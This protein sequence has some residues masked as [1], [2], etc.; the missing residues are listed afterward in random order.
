MNHP[1]TP[2]SSPC[3]SNRAGENSPKSI[4]ISLRRDIEWLQGEKSIKWQIPVHCGFPQ[5]PCLAREY[6]HH[7]PVVD[8]F[9]VQRHCGFVKPVFEYSHYSS[10]VD[11][12]SLQ[13]MRSLHYMKIY[14]IWVSI[15][16]YRSV[17]KFIQRYSS[18]VNWNLRLTPETSIPDRRWS[19]WLANDSQTFTAYNWTQLLW[20]NPFDNFILLHVNS[21][22]EGIILGTGSGHDRPS[23]I[24]TSFIIG[25]SHT[26]NDLRVSSI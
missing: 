21:L 3:K 26:Q 4:L 23:Y 14:V 8:M 19:N 10:F 25:S 15:W 9:S 16:D 1:H 20:Y 5:P 13:C 2:I 17:Y 24:V 6:P 11:M 7:S 22:S 18:A 12:H